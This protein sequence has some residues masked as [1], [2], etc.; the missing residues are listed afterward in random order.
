MIEKL[1]RYSRI[2]AILTCIFLVSTV[3]ALSQDDEGFYSAIKTVVIDAGHGGKDPG[4]HGASAKEKHVC[5]SMA[6][7]LGELISAKYP[8]IKV[9]YTRKT[10]VFV[11]LGER[12]KIAN[13]SKADLFI[14]IHAN[15]ASPAAYGTETYVLG[16]HRTASQQKVA[17]RENSTIHFEEDGGAKYKDFDMSPDAIIARQIQ[18]SVFLDQSISFA[19]KLQTEFKGLGRHDRGVKQAGFLVLYKT[20][21]PSVL[22]ETGFLTNPKEEN[23]LNTLETQKKMSGSMF[24]AFQKYKNELEGVEEET[25][26][27]SPFEVEETIID[28]NDEDEIPE[29]LE[30]KVEFRVQ[31]E[32]SEKKISL[33]ASK[34]K[35]YTVSQYT[36]NGLFKYTVGTYVNDFSAANAMKKKLRSGGFQHAFVVGFLNGE[37]INLQKAIKLAEN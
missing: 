16:L 1:K 13:R 26:N 4:C 36:Q 2:Y 30:N 22:I 12:A 17:E 10:D 20:T 6:L 5:L 34:F 28:S 27:I 25:E 19:S 15:A 18:L 9:V 23:F 8:H 11:E 7:Q 37:R 21:M 14:C 29:M 24:I 33:T 3:S 35:G 32:T 31:I